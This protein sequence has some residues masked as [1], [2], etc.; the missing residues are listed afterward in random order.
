M[1][2]A[3]RGLGKGIDAL[4]GGG[5]GA[6]A[7]EE[8]AATVPVK[9][10]RPGRL[11]PRA[12]MDDGTLQELARSIRERGV[13]QPIIARRTEDG[14]LEIVA[15]E[16]RWQAARIAGLEQVPVRIGDY[17]DQQA[18]YAALVENLQREDLN[19]VDLA[20]GLQALAKDF[21]LSHE[22]V[23]K[24]VGL[25]RPTVTNLIR[26]LGLHPDVLALAR[27]REIE[28]GHARALL[29]LPKSTQPGVARQVVARHLSVRQTEDLVRDLQ[30]RKADQPPKNPGPDPDTERLVERISGQLGTKVAIRASGKSKGRVVIHYASLD[31]LDRIVDKLLG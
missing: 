6:P 9:S 5:K 23:A 8:T 27:R 14:E 2:A 22:Q 17:D 30:G 15:G 13:I 31:T 21:D 1:S 28:T 11:Q 10:L 20:K 25:A 18:L 12:S 3:K 7:A 4:F 29:A 16:R 26:I 24:G 19:P